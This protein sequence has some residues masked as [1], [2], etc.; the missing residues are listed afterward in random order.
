M[1]P[2]VARE[3][4]EITRNFSKGKLVEGKVDSDIAVAQMAVPRASGV[5]PASK[6]TEGTEGETITSW[7]ADVQEGV[8]MPAQRT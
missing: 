6:G 1:P 5:D 3:I 2:S 4:F 8:V 7:I